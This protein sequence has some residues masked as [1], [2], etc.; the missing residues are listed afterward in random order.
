MTITHTYDPAQYVLVPR[1]LSPGMYRRMLGRELLNMD[2]PAFASLKQ[3]YSEFIAAAP[4]PPA[5]QTDDAR[6]REFK[7]TLRQFRA[8]CQSEGD[9]YDSLECD[10]LEREIL[11]LYAA[12]LQSQSNEGRICPH[13]V[14]H[15]TPCNDCVICPGCA[16]QFPAIP[17]NRQADATDAARYRW[18][19]DSGNHYAD[20]IAPVILVKDVVTGDDMLAEEKLDEAI[21]AARGAK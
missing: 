9:E 15:G 2:R 4:P 20:V 14:A 3:T 7:K 11:A 21:D 6:M 19:R 12:A 10:V 13:G 16:H 1:D 5:P 18:L 8:E 17:V